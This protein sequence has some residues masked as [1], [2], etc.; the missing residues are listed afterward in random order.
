MDQQHTPSGIERMSDIVG[1]IART[2][3]VD[4]A[5][6]VDSADDL[7][8]DELDRHSRAEESS[9]EELDED[10]ADDKRDTSGDVP[11]ANLE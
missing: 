11:V 4:G 3:I 10:R 7:S 2:L 1:N 8:E 5:D 9:P 6:G